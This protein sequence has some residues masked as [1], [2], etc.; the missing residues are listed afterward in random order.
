[1][2]QPNP[3]VLSA[4]DINAP[5][6]AATA[7]GDGKTEIKSMDYHRQMLQSRLNEDQANKQYVSPSDGIM[8]PCTAKLSA[9]RNKHFMKAKP[10]SLFAKASSKNLGSAALSRPDQSSE[11]GTDSSAEESAAPSQESSIGGDAH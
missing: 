2:S 4:R 6:A 7:P 1:M 8:S 9:Y 3:V 5:I 10:Q 11:M